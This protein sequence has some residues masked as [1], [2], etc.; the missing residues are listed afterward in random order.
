MD[1]CLLERVRTPD[2][3]HPAPEEK[4]CS[5]KCAGYVGIHVIRGDWIVALIRFDPERDDESNLSLVSTHCSANSLIHGL[6]SINAIPSVM[7][8]LR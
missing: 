1:I 4:K 3:D 5:G 8:M 6:T 7:H 2:D